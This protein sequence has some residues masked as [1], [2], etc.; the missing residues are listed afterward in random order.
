MTSIVV[1]K[2]RI[3]LLESE[4]YVAGTKKVYTMK[5]A[6]S[7][8]WDGLD[9]K[10]AFKT[11]TFE[12]L[13]DILETSECF[14][15]PSEVFAQPT[16][17]LQVGA[18]GYSCDQTVLNTR[19]TSLGRVS[20]GTMENDCCCSPIP[21]KP[22]P[23]TYEFLKNLIDRKADRLTIEDG[24]LILW[25]GDDPLSSFELPTCSCSKPDDTPD[26]GPETPDTPDAPPNGP[27]AS[28]RAP[29]GTIMAWSGALRDIPE[30][31]SL[32][33]GQNGTPD[34]RHA[35]IVGASDDL[36]PGTVIEAGM[37]STMAAA[38]STPTARYYA[39]AFIQ[40]TSLTEADMKEGQTAYDLAVEQGFDGSLEDYLE[41]LHGDSAYDLAV[42][43]GYTGSPDEFAKNLAVFP[44]IVVRDL[45]VTT[46]DEL[47]MKTSGAYIF[48]EVYFRAP[49]V[50]TNAL[51]FVN[52]FVYVDLIDPSK[53]VLTE[54]ENHRYEISL[55]D[56][57]QITAIEEIQVS[58][59]DGT[60]TPGAPG[61]KGDPGA[62]AYDIAVQNGFQGDEKQWLESLKGA[63]GDPGAQGPAGQN[64][65]SAY[66]IAQAHG[67]QEG[68]E[69]WLAS[70]KGSTGLSAYQVAKA[71]GFLGS[72][73]EWVESLKGEPG[74]AGKDGPA[75]QDGKSAYDI[76]VDE[77]FHGDKEQWLESLKGAK[78]DPGLPAQDGLSAYQI[79]V[80]HGFQG[81]EEQW[82]E[83]LKGKDGAVGPVGPTGSE[84]PEGKP[85]RD[86]QNGTNGKS[87]YELA[88][89]AGFDGDEQAWLA[90]LKG[91]TGK[92]VQ[93]LEIYSNDPTIVGCWI[94]KRPVYRIARIV[95]T[96]LESTVSLVED[97]TGVEIIKQDISIR[98]SKYGSSYT[99]P[100]PCS[101]LDGSFYL[102]FDEAL[103]TL[104]LRTDTSETSECTITVILEY[105]I[106][107]DSPLTDD[108]LIVDTDAK[109]SE[110]GTNDH[111]K[112]INRNVSKQHTISAIDGLSDQLA[113][114]PSEAITDE[115]LNA[116]FKTK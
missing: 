13:V 82:L 10:V 81:D 87:A 77:G 41:S 75:G 21:S 5:I 19:W 96:R 29:V 18:F 91:E 6:F 67:F 69:E 54:L 103:G 97:L 43:G 51:H 100:I 7:E 16:S 53:I 45:T 110:G 94:D 60:S 66:Q 9:K 88:R 109:P 28:L 1:G 31:Y 8:D 2:D 99:Y 105:V 89:D 42:E 48:Q 61:P 14:P 106:N 15:M 86:G 50:R 52:D 73:A 33:D 30:S 90:S 59:G 38:R 49:A 25:A 55:S 3:S 20:A 71:N 107:G 74:T 22:S 92:S 44:D 84:G 40:K 11:D 12:M 115:Q 35:M 56:S 65:Q 27:A 79:A 78:G 4:R 72:E 85:G 34:L 83:S 57:G 62:S 98:Y 70:L 46:K 23:V 104:Y 112:L 95:S 39:L 63:T 36:T 113:A 101:I 116:L 108:Q 93:K 37:Y 80:N 114:T 111:T 26:P 76:A 24:M 58:T 102:Q 32:C 17:K 68:E 64:G 47:P